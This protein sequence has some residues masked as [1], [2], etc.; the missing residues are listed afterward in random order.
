MYDLSHC[1]FLLCTPI[2]A[3]S[4]VFISIDGSDILRQ[5]RSLVSLGA[6]QLAPPPHVRDMTGGTLGWV[7]KRW[8]G[9]YRT[10]DPYILI[11]RAEK[12]YRMRVQQSGVV[13][14]FQLA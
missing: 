9:Q 5:V 7:N 8:P 11:G 6:P 2:H 13:V 1:G 3:Q 12:Q 14:R 10:L 4:L